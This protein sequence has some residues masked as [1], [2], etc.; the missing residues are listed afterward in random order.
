MLT[1]LSPIFGNKQVALVVKNLPANTGDQR[2][3]GPTPGLGRPLEEEMAI[4]SNIIAWRIPRTKEL[5]G[6]QSIELH[7][8]GYD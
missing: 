6:L 4:H 1:P 8:I 7:R 2:D 3:V 5:G